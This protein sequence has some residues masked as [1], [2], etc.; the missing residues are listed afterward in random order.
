MRKQ[1][2]GRTERERTGWKE[3]GKEKRGSRH[4][5]GSTR[6]DPKDFESAVKLTLALA[7]GGGGPSSAFYKGLS[8]MKEMQQKPPD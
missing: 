2:D 7:G 5:V 1:T 4:N 6:P 3:R 8:D